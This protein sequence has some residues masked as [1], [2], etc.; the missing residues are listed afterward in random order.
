[1]GQVTQLVLARLSAKPQLHG[2]WITLGYCNVYRAHPGD[3]QSIA[4]PRTHRILL[5]LKNVDNS[6]S[7]LDA[8]LSRLWQD[9]KRAHPDLINRGMDSDYNIHLD[10]KD[11]PQD[12]LAL[13]RV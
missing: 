5:L 3:K 6:V 1:M 2:E 10:V 4:I 9:L 13:G 7:Q 12:F 11:A 8:L